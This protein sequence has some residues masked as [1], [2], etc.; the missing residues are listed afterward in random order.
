M[1]SMPFRSGIARALRVAYILAAF[2]SG[3]HGVTADGRSLAK[4]P[5]LKELRIA[6]EGARPPYN[7][8]DA[9]NELAGLEID[10]GRALCQRLHV[11]CQFIQQDWDSM[12]PGLVSN[13]YDAIMAAM[14]ITD[15]R[16]EKI[17][18]SQPYVRMPSA[19]VVTREPNVADA[20]PEG[21]AGHSI[22]VESGSRQQA[23]LEAVY[24]NSDIRLYATLEEAVLDLAQGRIDVALGDK[25]VVLDFLTTRK[26]GQCCRLLG[27]VAPDPAYF[28]E[29]IAI[30]LRQ[31]DTAL[32]GQ[33][34]AALSALI[35]DGTYLKIRSRYFN[36]AVD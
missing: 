8:L 4:A 11:K 19:F 6:S 14:E 31:E 9:N 27:D 36:F 28:G 7:Y 16:R 3:Q 24:K 26:E 25:D 1:A 10:L 13:H 29:G 34:N 23:Y 15:E 2:T 20:S 33:L 12:I 30:G 22:G 21:L 17:A 32:Q 5:P 35:A 18:F